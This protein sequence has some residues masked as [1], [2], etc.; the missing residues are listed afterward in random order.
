MS[1]LVD[2]HRHMRDAMLRGCACYGDLNSYFRDVVFTY[3]ANY[4]SENTYAFLCLGLAETVDF[5]ITTLHAWQQNPQTRQ[6]LFRA[7]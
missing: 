5:G 3:G 2:T 6:L 7:A 4:T 1:G